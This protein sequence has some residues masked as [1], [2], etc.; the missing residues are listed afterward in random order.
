MTVE[1]E[2]WLLH[3]QR[4]LQGLLDS[5]EAVF[6]RGHRRLTFSASQS[7]IDL[8][9]LPRL[10]RLRS[11]THTEI[12]IRTMVVGA[13]EAPEDDVIHIRYGSGDWPHPYRVRLYSEEL[14]PVAAPSVAAQKQHW[15]ALPRI[16]CAG[17]R[18]GWH[19]WTETFG[20]PGS[21][22]PQLRFDTHLSA[23]AA[24]RSGLGVFLASLPLCASDLKNG[25][26]VRLEESSLAHHESY[27]LLAST[28]AL[29]RDQWKAMTEI[30]TEPCLGE[31]LC[32]RCY[33]SQMNFG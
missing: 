29:P 31:I 22:F 23:L 14:V 17:A 11:L 18:P 15:T 8:W 20:I 3:V 10:N 7:M 19:A 9:L 30:M 33:R 6:G 12:A 26:L 16:T 24:A 4:A 28:K 2:A 5:S 25:T 32:D 1:G 13:L 27:W 21:P